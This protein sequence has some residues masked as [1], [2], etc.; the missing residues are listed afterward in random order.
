[1]GGISDIRWVL[2]TAVILATI[3]SF[4]SG[5]FEWFEKDKFDEIWRKIHMANAESCVTAR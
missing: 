5:Q 1:M 4:T 2:M 3:L